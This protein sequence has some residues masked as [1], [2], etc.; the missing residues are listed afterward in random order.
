MKDENYFFK[1]RENK[2][3]NL[4]SALVITNGQPH[5]AGGYTCR[6]MIR[7]RDEISLTHRL[8]VNTHS[9]KIT[10]V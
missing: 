2:L 9:F 4:I 3:S 1:I 8:I 5:D 6:V 7:A 10:P